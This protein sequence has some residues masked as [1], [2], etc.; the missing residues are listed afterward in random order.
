MLTV[1]W[2]RIPLHDGVAAEPTPTP[3]PVPKTSALG[4]LWP[5]ET[6]V[7]DFVL[8]NLIGLTQPVAGVH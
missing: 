3:I 8:S 4:Q 7:L 1:S 6:K 2:P 5:F